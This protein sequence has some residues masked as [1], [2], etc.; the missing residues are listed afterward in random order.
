MLVLNT[1]A[2][3]SC[4][5]DGCICCNVGCARLHWRYTMVPKKKICVIVFLLLSSNYN[6]GTTTNKLLKTGM[7]FLW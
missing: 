7:F 1:M 4:Y 6:G 2:L 5:V 3:V